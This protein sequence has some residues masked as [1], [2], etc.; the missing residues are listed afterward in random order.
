VLQIL[1]QKLLLLLL[2]LL[3]LAVATKAAAVEPADTWRAPAA[4]ADLIVAWLGAQQYTGDA[5]C[6]LVTAAAISPG[7]AVQ[8]GYSE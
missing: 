7:S 1:L 2:L 6:R 8:C 3:L 4:A 5:A